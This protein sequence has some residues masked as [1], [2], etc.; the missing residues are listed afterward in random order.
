MN[1]IKKFR[2]IEKDGDDKAIV[3]QLKP[4]SEWLDKMRKRK[5]IK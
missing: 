2:D 4:Y 3:E 5:K 1:S